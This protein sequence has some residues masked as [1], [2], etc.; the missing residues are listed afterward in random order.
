MRFKGI[1][2]SISYELDGLGKL[3]AKQCVACRE[4]KSG[5]RYTNVKD[6]FLGKHNQCNAC[7][8]LVAETARRA[9]GILPKQ[10]QITVEDGVTKRPCSKCKFSKSLDE[11]D[12]NISGHL[13]HDSECSEC[14]RRRGEL[15]RRDKGIRP[16][17]KVPILT[18]TLGNPTDRECYRCQKMLPLS[19]FNKHAMAYLGV[20]P[21]CKQ[22]SAERHLIGKYGLTSADKAQLH[23]TQGEACAICRESVALSEIHVDH[24]HSTGKVRGLL[25]SSCNKALGLLKDN[26]T[27]CLNMA[28]YLS[29]NAVADKHS[30]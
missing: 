29:A 13:G 20:H 15:Y 2:L 16:Q 22:C 28:A 11:F 3:L 27:S 7:L 4:M 5:D 1:Q 18:D 30:K 25:C 26:P 17:R 12:K 6:S 19:Q 23:K 21:Y 14:K 8:A 9:K 24:C 10:P